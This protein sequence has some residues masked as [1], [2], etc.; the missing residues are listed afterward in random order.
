MTKSGARVKPNE[1][2]FKATYRDKILQIQK[3]GMYFHKT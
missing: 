1:T 3:C 2:Q